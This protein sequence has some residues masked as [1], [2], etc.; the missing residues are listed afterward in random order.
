MATTLAGINDVLKVNPPLM[1]HI[2]ALLHDPE[3]TAVLESSLK[4]DEGNSV[5][6]DKP[7]ERK[8]RAIVKRFCNLDRQ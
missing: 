4:I 1:Y 5:G 6:G 7:G 8:L 2:S 3:W